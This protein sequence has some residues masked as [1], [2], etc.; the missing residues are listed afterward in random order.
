MIDVPKPNSVPNKLNIIVLYFL[1]LPMILFILSFIL[2]IVVSTIA[3]LGIYQPITMPNNIK[4]NI[5]IILVSFFVVV[6]I[7]LIDFMSSE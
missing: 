3:G 5:L 2:F 1:N 4:T 6:Y 7:T